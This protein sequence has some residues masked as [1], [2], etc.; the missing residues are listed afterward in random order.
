MIPTIKEMI[1]LE[2]ILHVL[3]NHEKRLK[4]LERP[5]KKEEPKK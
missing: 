1:K 3:E 2:K 4:Q 5:P